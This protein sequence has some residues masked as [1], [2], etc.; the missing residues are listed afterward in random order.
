MPSRQKLGSSSHLMCE[1][2]SFSG[3]SGTPSAGLAHLSSTETT[4]PH[5]T[6]ISD[7][8]SPPGQ[9]ADAPRPALP[10]AQAPRPPGR[11][12]DE[13]RRDVPGTS[14]C[15]LVVG[16]NPS[17]SWSALR[18]G[19]VSTGLSRP[20]TS[21]ALRPQGDAARPCGPR[22]GRGHPSRPTRER[23]RRASPQGVL[24]NTHQTL[25]SLTQQRR[26]GDHRGV[27]QWRQP[28]RAGLS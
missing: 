10:G 24:V 2:R 9:R 18:V 21:T 17:T 22:V 5:R 14:C 13:H 25:Y 6:E 4:H 8:Q 23:C 20:G 19:P 16:R 3:R 28:T 1:S 26:D 7:V 11:D 15:H 27:G 12:R